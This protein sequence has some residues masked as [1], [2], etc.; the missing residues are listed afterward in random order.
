[1]LGRQSPPLPRQGR[2]CVPPATAPVSLSF[3]WEVLAFLVTGLS[4]G[5]VPSRSVFPDPIFAFVL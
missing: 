3:S 4:E 1:M 2:E 5:S